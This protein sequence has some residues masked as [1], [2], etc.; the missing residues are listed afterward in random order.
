MEW[1]AEVEVE[2]EVTATRP[3]TLE[4]PAGGGAESRGGFLVRVLDKTETALKS[5]KEER[6]DVTA[7]VD[8]DTLSE[9]ANDIYEDLEDS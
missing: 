8:E 5:V 4:Q 3:A 2:Y 9:W 1:Q 7:F 6:G